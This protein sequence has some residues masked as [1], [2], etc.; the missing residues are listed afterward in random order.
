MTLHGKVLVADDHPL[1]RMA[2]KQAVTQAFPNATV[3]EAENID[4]L[5]RLTDGRGA[6]F[7][8]VVGSQHAR[9]S[10]LF[11]AHIHA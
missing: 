11:R 10:W 9:S 2:L 5:E 8:V 3:V 7:P 1:F 4:Q 6:L